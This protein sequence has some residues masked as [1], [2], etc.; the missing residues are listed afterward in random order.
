MEGLKKNSAKSHF[1][2]AEHW[3]LMVTQRD[4]ANKYKLNM[5]LH[6]D[7]YFNRFIIIIKNF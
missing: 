6:L 7:L 4:K 3:W 5:Y 1:V 2:M